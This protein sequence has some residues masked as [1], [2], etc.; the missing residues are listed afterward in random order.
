MG[1]CWLRLVYKSQVSTTSQ[2]SIQQ[3]YVGNLKSAAVRDYLYHG[4]QKMLKFRA[5]FLVQ[6]QFRKLIVKHLPMHH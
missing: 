5:F 4:N 2:R 6:N 3:D 1:W